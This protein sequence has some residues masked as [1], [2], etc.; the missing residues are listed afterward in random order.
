MPVCKCKPWNRIEAILGRGFEYRKSCRIGKRKIE[1]EVYPA[2]G[3][4]WVMSGHGDGIQSITRR[5]SSQAEGLPSRRLVA[6]ADLWLAEQCKQAS[7][8]LSGRRRRR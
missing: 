8:S 6:E 1:I 3:G 5:L 7:G 4:D 2:L